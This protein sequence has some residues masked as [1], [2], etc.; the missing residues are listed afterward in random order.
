MTDILTISICSDSEM[1]KRFFRKF[2]CDGKTMA[3]QFLL[4]LGCV[5]MFCG[6]EARVADN[7]GSN[8]ASNTTSAS[9]V[10][11]HAALKFTPANFKTEVLDSSKVVLVDVWAPW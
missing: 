2:S 3:K 8:P 1:M 7:G 9:E 6:C 5:V 11:D 10:D 4:V